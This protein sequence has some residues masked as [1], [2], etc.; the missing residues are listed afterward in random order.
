MSVLPD[1]FFATLRQMGMTGVPE[2]FSVACSQQEVARTVVADIEAFIAV[3]DRVTTRS[4]WQEHVTRTVPEIARLRR[5]EVCFFSAW[6]FH[7]PDA[8]PNHWQLIEFNDNGSGVMS[9]ALINRIFYEMGG[10]ERRKDIEAP[11]PVA[12]FCDQLAV[13]I[14]TEAEAFFGTRPPE[15][16]LI[17]DDAES[18]ERGRFRRELILLRDL[19]RTRGWRAEIGSADELCWDGRRLLRQHIEVSFVINRSTDFFW[20]GATFSA[21]AAAYREGRV[22]VAPNPFTYATRSDKRLLELLSHRDWDEQLGIEAAERALLER[23]VPQTWLVRADNVD[24]L[25]EHKDSLVFK[26]AHG[27]AGHGLLP[28]SQVGRSRLRRL[29]KRGIPYVAQRCVPKP[30]MS[31]D[32][33]RLWTDLRVWS[34]RG[35][36]FL[37][38]GRASRHPG[39]IDLTPPGGWLP[40]YL[41][42]ESRLHGCRE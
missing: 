31:T 5:A 21:L 10:M 30:S 15:S 29:L 34:Y 20:E 36:R 33:Q 23:H 16:L 11:L 8:L 17:L 6:D 40:T 24:R 25:V 19:L 42:G 18:L 28:A 9:A 7:L 12:A 22:Y 2:E 41:Q 27:F 14:G 39:F 38:S 32:G 3:F 35:R 1:H 13:M 26:P 4:A 37:L